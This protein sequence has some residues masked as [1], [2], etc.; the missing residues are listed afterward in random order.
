MLAAGPSEI[1]TAG[2]NVILAAG[3]SSEAKGW[4]LVIRCNA[5]LASAV[6]WHAGAMC[7]SGW[8]VH[9]HAI[10][11]SCNRWPLQ[12]TPHSSTHHNIKVN[13]QAP[14]ILSVGVGQADSVAAKCVVQLNCKVQRPACQPPQPM[15]RF[16][17]PLAL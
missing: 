16:A 6:C 12:I 11:P 13:P 1:L 14:L 8:L 7:V 9:E 3:P 15:E 17:K 10:S 2:Y 4:L 5:Q